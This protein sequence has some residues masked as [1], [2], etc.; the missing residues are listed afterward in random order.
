MKN[1]IQLS[2]RGQNFLYNSKG[3]VVISLLVKYYMPL[4]HIKKFLKLLKFKS[5]INLYCF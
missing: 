4:A 2:I 5:A 3:L 1:A